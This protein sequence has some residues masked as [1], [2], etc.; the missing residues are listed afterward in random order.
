[1]RQGISTDGTG[2][3]V[4]GGGDGAG[5]VIAGGGDGAGVVIAGGGVGACYCRR[6]RWGGNRGEAGFVFLQHS[7]ATQVSRALLLFYFSIIT[8]SNL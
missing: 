3:V 6:R 5:V 2:V 1:M 4:G 8:A 7:L